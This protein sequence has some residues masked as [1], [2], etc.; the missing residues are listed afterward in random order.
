MNSKTKDENKHVKA[1]ELI[2]IKGKLSS[3]DLKINI[4]S[5]NQDFNQTFSRSIDSFLREV[6]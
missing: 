3:F 5:R 4:E 2:Q 1:N 6:C